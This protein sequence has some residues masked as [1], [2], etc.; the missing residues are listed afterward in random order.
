MKD[1]FQYSNSWGFQHPTF[2]NGQVIQT[3]NQERNTWVNPY[4][5]TN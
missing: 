3:E 5:R 4:Y 1:R 2:L